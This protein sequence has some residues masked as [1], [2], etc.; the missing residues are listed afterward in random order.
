M[1]IIINGGNIKSLLIIYNKDMVA[2]KYMLDCGATNEAMIRYNDELMDIVLLNDKI[3][4]EIVKH[5]RMIN[6]QE[7][8][9][10]NM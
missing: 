4:W 7:L 5:L 8:V 3:Y 10:N 1:V 2:I 6:A 9:C